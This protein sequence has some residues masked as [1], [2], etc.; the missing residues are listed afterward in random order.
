MNK[1]KI[2]LLLF[3]VLSL[4]GCSIKRITINAT[5]S[6]MEDVV[7]AFFEEEDIDFAK[8][9]VP[10]NL[11]LLDGLI[12]GSNYENDD[13]L[14]KGCKLYGMYAMG[15]LEDMDTDKK[16]EKENLKKASYFYKKAKDYGMK[17]LT[18]N[19]DFKNV[20]D[21]DFSEFEKMMI[22][23][24]KKDVEALF[25][26]AFAWGSFINLN[27]NSVE[28]VSD[29]PKVRTM[30]ARV[31]ELDNKYFYGLPHLFMIVYYS[32]PKM[33]GGD[34]EKAKQEYE[35]VKQISGGK[36]ILADFFTAKFYT[37]QKQDK[38]LFDELLLNI[39]KTPDDIIPEKLFTKIAK[40]KAEILKI[41]LSD[42]F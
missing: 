25:W 8:E 41:K 9:A 17:I 37:V 2:F 27:K 15:F 38:K 18:K 29:L 19:N 40:K 1:I 12:K 21:K 11:K 7:T 20:L 23:F 13:L 14:L 22:A 5:G 34:L 28:A 10:A 39:E 32:M 42:A 26:T 24:N 6:F 16:K 33:F 35:K 4:S 36:F 30:M 31:L 3:L